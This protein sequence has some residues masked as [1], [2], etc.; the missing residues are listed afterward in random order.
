L[1][2]RER[3]KTEREKIMNQLKDNQEFAKLTDSKTQNSYLAIHLS[4][5]FGVSNEAM[6]IALNDN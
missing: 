3:L 1:I 4:Y 5:I 2:P 6:E